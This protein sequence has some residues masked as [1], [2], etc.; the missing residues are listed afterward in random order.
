MKT[1]TK[2]QLFESGDVVVNALPSNPLR[3]RVVSGSLILLAG[4]GLVGAANLIYNVAVARMLGPAGFGHVAAVY[5]L[6]M[7]MSAVTLAFQIV[8]AKLVAKHE[9]S[10]EKAAVYSGLRRPAVD[11]GAERSLFV[12]ERS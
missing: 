10:F 1:A 4:S 9:S 12:P 5:T 11:S 7:L 2:N 3:S 6:L 8:C